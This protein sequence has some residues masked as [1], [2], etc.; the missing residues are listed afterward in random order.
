[1]LQLSL[2]A[3][4]EW[5][6]PRFAEVCWSIGRCLQATDWSVAQLPPEVCSEARQIFSGFG[7]TK[8]LEDAFKLLRDLE[9][10]QQA[11]RSVARARR[12]WALV[13]STLFTDAG[14]DS[15]AVPAVGERLPGRYP[16]ELHQ[17][18]RI[19][20]PGPAA[21]LPEILQ[22]AS[23]ETL[24]AAQMRGLVGELAYM[25]AWHLAGQPDEVPSWQV[26]F[27]RPREVYR[28]PGNK[29]FLC[30]GS[31]GGKFA[32]LGWPL[33]AHAVAAPSGPR[34]GVAPC[35]AQ[36]QQL[37]TLSAACVTSRTPLWITAVDLGS[38]EAYPSQ[39]A[40]P[41]GLRYCGLRLRGQGLALLQAGGL[42]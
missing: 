41:A 20:D 9:R 38:I 36:Q 32:A 17:S 13:Q 15:L 8:T 3:H 35:Q 11:N 22:G 30:L 10:S 24:T 5:A 14:R 40:S 23:W 16:E 4:S 27:L 2:L 33:D 25:Q 12:W 26:G 42:D 34:G 39:V 37:W 31:I 1:M 21:P 19:R 7:Q 6:Q 29:F 18:S 28:L